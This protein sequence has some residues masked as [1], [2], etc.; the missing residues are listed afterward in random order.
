MIEKGLEV[1]EKKYDTK[2][3]ERID[4]LCIDR[5]RDFVVTEKKKGKE[6][7]KAFADCN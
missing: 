2:D 3:F 1:E 4:L 5:N 6:S 7:G